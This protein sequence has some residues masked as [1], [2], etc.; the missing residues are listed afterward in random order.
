V[1]HLAIDYGQKRVGL[2]L[3][4]A[5]GSLATP[6][7]VLTVGNDD[8]AR[9]QVVAAARHEGADVLVV[10]LPLNMDGTAGGS[11]RNVRRWTAALVKDLALPARLVD[12]RLSSVAAEQELAARRRGGERLTH[13]G[14]KKRLDAVAAAGFLQAHLDGELPTIETLTP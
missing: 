9:R 8:D 1:R 2:A 13:K 6:L 11:A 10:G 3:S 12:E 14:K 5:G 4:D 7:A